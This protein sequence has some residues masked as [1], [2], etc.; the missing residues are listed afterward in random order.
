MGPEL[1]CPVSEVLVI[2]VCHEQRALAVGSEP[3]PRRRATGTHLD[4]S[5]GE[6]RMTIDS[7]HD[8]TQ[9]VRYVGGFKR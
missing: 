5:S 7:I 9:W 3:V 1:I 4:L 6:A 2:N 8:D